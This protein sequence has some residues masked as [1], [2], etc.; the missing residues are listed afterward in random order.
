MLCVC[1]VDMSLFSVTLCFIG[2]VLGD[3]VPCP[4]IQFNGGKFEYNHD[5]DFRRL[6]GTIKCE[7]VW[8]VASNIIIPNHSAC[9]SDSDKLSTVTQTAFNYI[10]AACMPDYMYYHEVL[11]RIEYVDSGH[12]LI[13]ER[14]GKEWIKTELKGEDFRSLIADPDLF[15]QIR[16]GSFGTHYGEI[17]KISLFE[18]L[19]KIDQL[20]TLGVSAISPQFFGRDSL[21][22]AYENVQE[23]KPCP[24]L[25]LPDNENH[26]FVSWIDEATR[27]IYGYIRCESGVK[28]G[29]SGL[30]PFGYTKEYIELSDHSACLSESDPVLHGIVN[31]WCVTPLVD[32]PR[33]TKVLEFKHQTAKGLVGYPVDLRVRERLYFGWLP[34]KEGLEVYMQ[35]NCYVRLPED[36]YNKRF[37]R[38]ERFLRDAGD[39]SDSFTKSM[40][41]YV[42]FRNIQDDKGN[43]RWIRF[44][45]DGD[46][47][48]IV[49]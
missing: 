42:K 20:I 26:E 11:T 45:L 16:V 13:W 33:I 6:T 29:K 10:Q 22:I 37:V 47:A 18:L 39:V 35:P 28:V 32:G 2:I 21:P 12:P 36:I 34:V 40:E 25:T 3:L 14:T 31:L 49:V 38:V 7:P 5:S 17:W 24:A 43:T 1:I 44:S 48:I 23:T 4:S 8:R 9:P 27:K 46:F 30:N 15:A 41:S 19:F